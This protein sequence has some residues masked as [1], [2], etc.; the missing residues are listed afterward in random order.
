MK[1][2]Y[3]QILKRPR[4]EWKLEVKVLKRLGTVLLVFEKNLGE[5]QR[6]LERALSLAP[7]DYQVLVG[8]G[9]ALYEQKQLAQAL[10]KWVKAF[11]IN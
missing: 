5:A 4:L 3:T 9:I 11:N 2:K 6:L 7:D 1:E 10:E 8:L